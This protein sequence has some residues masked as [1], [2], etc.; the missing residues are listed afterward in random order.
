M[1]FGAVMLWGWLHGQ[2]RW[3]NPSVFDRTG[4]SKTDRQFLDLYYI[5]LVLAPLLLGATLFVY[6]LRKWFW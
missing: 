3:F 2:S 6:G 1:S 5:A 4:A